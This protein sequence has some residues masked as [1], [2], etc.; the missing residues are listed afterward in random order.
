MVDIRG[1]QSDGYDDAITVAIALAE[2]EEWPYEQPAPNQIILY[3]TGDRRQ[4]AVT[5]ISWRQIEALG[6][7]CGFGVNIPRRRTNA[8]NAVLVEAN[9]LC[10]FGT[11]IYQRDLKAIMYSYRLNLADG[12]EVTE[13]QI[14]SMVY[15][16]IASCDQ[17]YLTFQL[18]A[19]ADTS[20]AEAIGIA[21]GNAYGWA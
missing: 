14:A 3:V 16:A 12:A 17:F 21:T 11:F 5:L 8:L 2:A 13:V 19:T 6:V 7:V 1:R 20:P 9:Q 10:D 18:I 15:D 4:H